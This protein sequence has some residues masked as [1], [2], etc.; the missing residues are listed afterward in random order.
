MMPALT[1]ILHPFPVP[2]PLSAPSIDQLGRNR[3]AC[4]D[5]CRHVVQE[6]AI[7]QMGFDRHLVDFA[8]QQFGGNQEEAADALVSG[9]ISHHAE[10]ARR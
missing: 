7:F 5:L 6:P 8:L 3:L 2:M 1:T 4:P 10:F 9:H